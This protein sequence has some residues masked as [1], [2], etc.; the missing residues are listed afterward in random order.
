MKSWIGATSGT[1]FSIDLGGG[2]EI[3]FAFRVR[4]QNLKFGF[5]T[6]IRISYAI[7]RTLSFNCHHELYI[8]WKSLI[9]LKGVN[10]LRERLRINHNRL[11]PQ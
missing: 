2:V 6:Q 9:E 4:L 11:S 5:K 1:D 8:F 7:E 10:N 3:R